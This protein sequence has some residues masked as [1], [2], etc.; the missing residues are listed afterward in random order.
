TIHMHQFMEIVI[1]LAN[2]RVHETEFS[3]TDISSGDVLV[4][5]KNGYHR[6]AKVHNLELMNLLFDSENLPMPLIDLYK[7]PD[8]FFGLYLAF[9]PQRPLP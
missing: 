2:S 9:L 4:I 1:I 5:P 3:E 6:Y 7:L 8:Y